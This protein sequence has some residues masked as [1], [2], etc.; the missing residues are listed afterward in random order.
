MPGRPRTLSQ[1]KILDA[2]AEVL[3]EDLS[4]TSVSERLGVSPQALYKYF[5]NAK[6][7]QTHLAAKLLWDFADQ[8]KASSQAR[9]LESLVVSYGFRYQEWLRQT[10]YAPTLFSSDY[11][12][13][14]FET[15]EARDILLR[16]LDEFIADSAACG[17]TQEAAFSMWCVLIDFL[18]NTKSLAFGSEESKHLNRSMADAVERQPGQFPHVA[19]IL[20][21]TPVDDLPTQKLF[22]LGLRALARGLAEQQQ[23]QRRD[24]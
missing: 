3:S 23:L 22:E 4:F 10:G 1:A 2:A 5:P 9:D 13:S 8:P 24:E 16:L 7:L 12:L 15:P 19:Q 18:L 20:E 14:S 21:R 6:S 17:A 11:D